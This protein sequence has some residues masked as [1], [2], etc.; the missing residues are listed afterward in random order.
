MISREPYGRI[1]SS[2]TSVGNFRRDFK[3]QMPLDIAV[4]RCFLL[5]G[6]GVL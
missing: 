3:E 5:H 2:R 6:V 1:S 4:R